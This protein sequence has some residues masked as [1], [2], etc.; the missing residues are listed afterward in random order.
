MINYELRVMSCYFD[1]VNLRVASCILRV[2]NF[3]KI[4]CTSCTAA[5]RV[6]IK[7]LQFL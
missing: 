6:K 5:L 3:K 1:K 7:K 2:A 4:N